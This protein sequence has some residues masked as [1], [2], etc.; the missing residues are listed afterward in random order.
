MIKI[1]GANYFKSCNDTM[2]Y[3]VQFDDGIIVI[4]E[5]VNNDLIMKNLL[6]IGLSSSYIKTN[7]WPSAKSQQT[8][9]N[10]ATH[11]LN[12]NKKRYKLL[13]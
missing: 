10:L 9:H 12:K 13:K 7:K 4:Y 2:N 1:V 11:W 3:S 6:S 5:H 8:R